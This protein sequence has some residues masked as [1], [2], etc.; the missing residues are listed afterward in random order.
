M[1][2]TTKIK[3]IFL[4]VLLAINV[5]AQEKT[6]LKIK[7]TVTD[8]HAVPIDGVYVIHLQTEKAVVANSSGDFEI[9]ATLGETLLFSA[10]G[11]KKVSIL[12]A[13]ANFVTTKLLVKMVPEVQHL[14]EVVIKTYNNINAVAL[15]IVS[16][17]QKKYTPAQRRLKTATGLDP[18]PDVGSMAGGSVS[19]DALFNL[20]SGRTAMLKKELEVEKK[21]HYLKLLQTLFDTNHFVH[22]LHIPVE[23]VKGF[24]YFAVEN[25][26][27]TI[28]LEQKNTTITTFLLGEL[29]VEY[30]KIIACQD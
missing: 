26:K 9:E 5:F 14:D 8:V 13:D 10:M 27:F 2:D 3:F 1:R 16:D 20:L 4:F 11:Y 24:Q 25:T 12:L 19:A 29:A 23:Y 15:G 18:T 7:G 30:Q 17:K 28:I 21:E 6:V 22:K